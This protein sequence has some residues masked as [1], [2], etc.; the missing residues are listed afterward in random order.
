MQKVYCNLAFGDKT[1]EK[2]YHDCQVQCF[3]GHEE[4]HCH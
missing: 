3:Q 1:S 2:G 4:P